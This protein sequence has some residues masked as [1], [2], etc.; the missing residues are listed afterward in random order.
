[1]AEYVAGSENTSRGDIIYMEGDCV[2]SEV[3]SA[4]ANFLKNN[5]T[6]YNILIHFNGHGKIQEDPT[7]AGGM[8]CKDNEY[9][10]LYEIIPLINIHA[11]KLVL[12]NFDDP[13]FEH[14]GVFCHNCK[15]NPI[16]G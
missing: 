8:L 5:P 7:I 4:I 11:Q 12:P 14:H 10:Y 16:K 9:L 2:K 3:L 15:I 13:E 1:M 6:V